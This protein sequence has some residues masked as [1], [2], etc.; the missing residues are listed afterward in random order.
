MKLITKGQTSFNA[1]Q[2]MCYFKI[3][4]LAEIKTGLK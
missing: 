3:K 2:N 4:I 1:L